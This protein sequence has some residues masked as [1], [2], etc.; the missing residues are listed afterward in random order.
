MGNREREK[1]SKRERERERESERVREKGCFENPQ[2]LTNKPT[3]YTS[4]LRFTTYIVHICLDT[5]TRNSVLT[6]KIR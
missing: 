3:D 2:W 5:K 4:L 6:Q 1:V